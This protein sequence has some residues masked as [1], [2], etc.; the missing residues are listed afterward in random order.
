M[1]L[2]D[3]A[4]YASLITDFRFIEYACLLSNAYGRTSRASRLA[5]KIYDLTLALRSELE[6]RCLADGFR[7]QAINLYYPMKAPEKTENTEPTT[8]RP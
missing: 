2:E 4:K 3:H 6:D 8:M 1:T 5:N 7:E